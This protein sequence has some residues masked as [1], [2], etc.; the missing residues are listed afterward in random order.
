MLFNSYIFIFLFLPVALLGWYILNH[1]KAY[2]LSQIFLCAMSLWFYAYFHIS[3]LFILMG[4]ILINY[5]LSLILAK[6]QSKT[7]TI[8]VKTSGIVLN[9][10]ILFVFKYYDFFIDSV[11]HLF[12]SDLPFLNILLPLGISFFTFQQMSYILDRCSGK[13]SHENL[14]DYTTFVSFFP[15]LIAGPIVRPNEFLPQIKDYSKRLFNRESFQKGCLYFI[16]GLFKKV[17]LAD[18]IGRIVDTGYANIAALDTPA[19]FLVMIAYTMQLYFD[20]SG[21]SDMAIGLGYMFGIELPE[22]FDE[23]FKSIHMQEFWNRWHITLGRFFT[24]YVYIPLGGSRRSA[25][26]TYLN[27][28]IIFL[29][30]G[31]WH[32]A[33]WT[34]ILWGIMQGIFVIAA[35]MLR[36]RFVKIKGKLIIFLL[37]THNFILFSLSLILFRSPSLSDSG[38]FFQRLFSFESYHATSYLAYQIDYSELWLPNKLFTGPLSQYQTQYREGTLI[39]IIIIGLLIL[40]SKGVKRRVAASKY[41]LLTA[42][43]AALLLLW[44]VISFSG[45]TTFLYFNF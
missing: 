13:A 14:L 37:Q 41:N 32:G 16:Y 25:P 40:C 39:I 7:S 45:V 6:K 42:I 31:I 23:P 43:G 30:S 18:N 4:S 5:L 36:N 9:L 2:K 3:Y 38:L 19:A 20:F 21:Y 12:A 26:R 17:I 29:L 28:F 10:G 35:R 11:N 33:N 8:I 1:F 24:S 27:I 44:S 34:F 22:N 15:Q